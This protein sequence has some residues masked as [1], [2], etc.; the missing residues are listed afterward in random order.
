MTRAQGCYPTPDLMSSQ[1]LVFSKGSCS[2]GQSAPWPV[3]L[4]HLFT[5]LSQATALLGPCPWSPG[6]VIYRHLCRNL[7]TGAGGRN[8]KDSV[9]QSDSLPSSFIVKA[10][11]M[12]GYNLHH[13]FPSCD[14]SPLLCPRLLWESFSSCVGLIATCFSVVYCSFIIL[15]VHWDS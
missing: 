9:S 4:F 14:M 12:F 1:C 2:Q 8:L 5:F 13:H 3:F 15:G 11:T 10:I 7:L 6:P